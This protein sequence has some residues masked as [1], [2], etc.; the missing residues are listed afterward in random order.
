MPLGLLALTLLVG[1]RLDEPPVVAE[2]GPPSLKDGA[3]VDD[4]KRPIQAQAEA[5][6]HS[7]KVPRVYGVPVDSGLATHR[8][9]PCAVEEGG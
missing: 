6:N 3:A 4:A 7:G 8:F 9:K 1:V 5:S 2:R